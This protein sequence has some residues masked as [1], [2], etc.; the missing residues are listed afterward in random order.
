MKGQTQPGYTLTQTALGRRFDR[1]K[2]WVRHQGRTVVG[3][4]V[5]NLQASRETWTRIDG[6]DGRLVGY[7]RLF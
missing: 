7:R 2:D 3:Y 1:G 4:A 5:K 6:P